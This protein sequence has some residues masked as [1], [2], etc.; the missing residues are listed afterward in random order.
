MC[1]RA[2]WL[3]HGK[4]MRSGRVGEVLEAYHARNRS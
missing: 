1:D 3:D 4:L 2:I